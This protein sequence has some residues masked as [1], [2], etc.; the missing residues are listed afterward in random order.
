MKSFNPPVVGILRIPR[1]RR[2]KSNAPAMVDALEQR[3]LL[4]G[5]GTLTA[6]AAFNGV[7]GYT[8]NSG[9]ADASGNIFGATLATTNDGGNTFG[10]GVVF[11]IP[12]GT[13]TI[14]DL[15][16][17]P[18]GAGGTVGA[19][20]SSGN[21]FG[22]EAGATASVSDTVFEVPAG[23]STLTPLATFPSQTLGTQ[24]T[25]TAVDSAGDVFGLAG[26]APFEIVKGSGVMTAL[27]NQNNPQTGFRDLQLGPGGNLYGIGTDQNDNTVIADVSPT[28]GDVTT[29][30]AIDPTTIGTFPQ[31][32]TFDS[33][34]NIWGLMQYGGS[35]SMGSIF[36]LP[37]GGNTVS[38]I[39]SFTAAT[40]DTP[41]GPPV[42]DASG[43]LYGLTENDGANGDGTLFEIPAGA[44]SAGP[45]DLVDLTDSEQ[46]STSAGF[47]TNSAGIAPA[48][49]GYT[50]AIFGG[51]FG[52]P[53]SASAAIGHAHPD[54]LSLSY[55]FA[56]GF[57][58]TLNFEPTLFSLTI[59]TPPTT[60]IE[61]LKNAFTN[62]TQAFNS[63]TGHASAKIIRG[64]PTANIMKDVENAPLFASVGLVPRAMRLDPQV[65]LSAPLEAIKTM[66][67]TTS[68][69]LKSA[70]KLLGK[71]TK[72]ADQANAE[73]NTVDSLQTELA[74]QTNASSKAKI[75]KKITADEATAT[76]HANQD[77]SDYNSLNTAGANIS[78]L[79][80]NIQTALNALPS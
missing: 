31:G 15:A 54:D 4:S 61:K 39:A 64:V 71:Q 1:A 6:I 62:L 24:G 8:P 29:L 52:A 55:G 60:D 77:N 9:V 20:D 78:A 32:I 37:A 65:K 35:A 25:V 51:L 14:N 57:S 75:Q 70:A 47:V 48:I 80:T 3:V 43:N 67:A 41:V 72:L 17:F 36:E 69:D 49:D 63:L 46:V 10:P 76:K 30:A 23:T 5:T 73:V 27:E 59:D 28:T 21:V 74:A 79:E 34:G 22:V 13:S 40:G 45:V 50:L 16:T 26:P 11:E 42:F 12:A 66:L 7:N 18:A 56:F 33:S 58:F 38:L 2:K 44:A 19:I 53:T 68:K